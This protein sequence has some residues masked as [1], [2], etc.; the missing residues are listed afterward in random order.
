MILYAVPLYMLLLRML[1]WI[2]IRHMCGVE[3]PKKPEVLQIGKGFAGLS[4][5]LIYL[6]VTSILLIEVTG[7]LLKNKKASELLQRL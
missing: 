1:L 3:L 4:D 5:Y 2:C 7:T 6:L